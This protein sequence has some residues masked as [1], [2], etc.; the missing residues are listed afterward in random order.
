MQNIVYIVKTLRGR[1]YVFGVDDTGAH[2]DTM[3]NFASR[4]EA[5]AFIA[6]LESGDA[7]YCSECAVWERR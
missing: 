4:A 5:D 2:Y 3:H 6:E 7:R 1:Y